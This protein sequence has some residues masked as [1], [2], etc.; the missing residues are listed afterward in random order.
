MLLDST[1]PTSL[2]SNC[3]NNKVSATNCVGSWKAKHLITNDWV[4]SQNTSKLKSTSSTESFWDHRRLLLLCLWVLQSMDL[5]HLNY[6]VRTN[7]SRHK[8]SQLTTSWISSKGKR[9]SNKTISRAWRAQSLSWGLPSSNFETNWQERLEKVR[10]LAGNLA[11]NLS[12]EQPSRLTTRII[13]NSKMTTGIWDR[14][15]NRWGTHTQSC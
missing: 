3:C 11:E 9:S 14:L 13:F 7:S 15:L 8:C 1:K 5:S 4:R 10:R 2:I 6:N 12:A